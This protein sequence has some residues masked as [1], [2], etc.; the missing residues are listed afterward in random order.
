MDPHRNQHQL[1]QNLLE[2]ILFL[3]TRFEFNLLRFGISLT[4]QSQG[5]CPEN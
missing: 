1:E 2:K 3:K 4:Q 5:M